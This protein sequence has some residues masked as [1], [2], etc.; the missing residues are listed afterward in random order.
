MIRKLIASMAIA[1][2]SAFHTFS[3]TAAG[4][5]TWKAYL[6]YSQVQDV[7]EAGRQLYVLASGSLY[8]YNTDDKSITTFSKIN[9]LNDCNISKI[10]YNKTVR[11]LIIVY[12]NFNID[13]MD[14]KGR[15]T[16]VSDY[17][18]ANLM[19]DKTI[20]DIS[21]AG[22]L[23]YLSTGFGI[24]KMNMGN[25][26]ISDTYNLGFKV[27]YT[28]IDGNAIHAMSA[29]R[30]HYSAPLTANLLDK[31]NWT[32]KGE[33]TAKTV[34][35]KKALKEIASTLAPGGPKYN[36]FGFMK[37][38]QGRLYTCGGGWGMDELNRPGTIQVL[39]DG[40][41]QI[42]E[43]DIATKTGYRYVDTSCLD[44]DPKNPDHVFAGGRTGVY[45]FNNGRFMKA[46]SNDNTNGCLHTASTVGNNNKDYVIV[47]SLTF[48]KT[49]K[50][51]MFNSISPSTSLVE[52]TDGK[53]KNLHHSELMY[54]DTRSLENIV[55]MMFDSRGLLWFC[56]DHYRTPSLF[57]Y[58][59]STGG[60]NP[61]KSLVNQDGNMIVANGGVN[62]VAED[63][64]GNI[65][66]GTSDGPLML[67]AQSIAGNGTTFEQV[68]VPR[69]D[70]TN[71]AD[72]LLSGSD[73][74][75]MAIDGA[76]RKWFG[77]SADGVYLISED[78]LVQLQHFTAENSK[79][80]SNSIES[81]AINQQTGEVFF[82]TGM[83]L[84]SY[85]S[86]ATATNETMTKDNVWA[87]PNP[88]RPDFTGLITVTGLSYNADVKI[89]TSNSVLVA[90]GRSNGGTFTWDGCD[91]K[92]RKVASGVYMV[93]TATASGD[94][95]VVCKIAI[96][97]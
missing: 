5:G 50:L 3:A 2:L 53:W 8:A 54:D 15:V 47:N 91:L 94:K 73:I 13:L 29:A 37:Y 96:V 82:G 6:S 93:Q 74:T 63:L 85:M 30:G 72:Y 75:C 83:G 31:S 68:K 33:Y 86:D 61:Y 21:H 4:I 39:K 55:G 40:E 36:Y 89:T 80:L 17:R 16:N 1:L 28:Y 95:G 84:C 26:E 58:Q 27:D 35:D 64:K 81:I 60:L 43:D 79:L 67:T 76:G 56:N 71:L 14:D 20:N 19:A 78:N 24:V 52:Y 42:Y 97:R 11:K 25:A 46:Y 66:I 69:N 90:N 22:S 41:W 12:E 10:S 32:R 7:E 34:E 9:G 18:N 65:W 51:W 92:G 59:T 48:D 57:A 23:A 87:Y 44:I 77:T 49:G 38:H 88:V 45:E 70:G 62:C